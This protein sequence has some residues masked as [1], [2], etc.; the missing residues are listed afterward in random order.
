MKSFIKKLTSRKFLACTAG[1]IIGAC[2]IF[3][4]D[5]NTVNTIAGAITSFGSVLIYIYSE[6]KIDAASVSKI[7]E[8]AK[9]V[10]NAVEV[11]DNIE[12]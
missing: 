8:A 1:M 3:G 11:V 6:G 7:A 4:L 2:M 5:I 12:E 10:K 9:D